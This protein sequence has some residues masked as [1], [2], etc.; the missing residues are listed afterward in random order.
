MEE[1]LIVSYQRNA[2]NNYQVSH[3]FAIF[4]RVEIKNNR[5]VFIEIRS[6]SGEVR[7]TIKRNNT[8]IELIIM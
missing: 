1:I 2:N 6:F 4:L 5:V 3:L 8:V 7:D